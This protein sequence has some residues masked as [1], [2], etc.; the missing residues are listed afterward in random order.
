MTSSQYFHKKAMRKLCVVQLQL[1]F[2]FVAAKYFKNGVQDIAIGAGG[3]RFESRVRQ[4]GRS[5]ANGSLPLRRF[6]GAASPRR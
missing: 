4:I 3:L 1:A 6:F 2:N 5:V